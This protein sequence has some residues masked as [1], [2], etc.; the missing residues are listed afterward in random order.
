[1][2]NS[3]GPD[4][5]R[6][7]VGPNLGPNC[8][9]KM[10]ADDTSRQRL[11]RSKRVSDCIAS[12]TVY[13]E[14]LIAFTEN[15]INRKAKVPLSQTGSTLARSNL[16]SFARCTLGL[17]RHFYKKIYYAISGLYIQEIL[18]KRE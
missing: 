5:A 13:R 1:M 8:L 14:S 3:L 10:S 15:I 9:Q 6:H 4:Q 12:G 2:S 17:N 7:F 18:T 11:K 16:P